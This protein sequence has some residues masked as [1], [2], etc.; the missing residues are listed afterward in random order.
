MR[1]TLPALIWIAACGGDADVPLES[2]PDE[3]PVAAADCSRSTSPLTFSGC[4]QNLLVITADTFRPD[5]LGRYGGAA[6]TPVIDALLGESL[7]LEDHRSCSNWTYVSMY[8]VQTGSYELQTG[9]IPATFE[10][11]GVHLVPDEQVL[12]S[13]VLASSGWQTGLVT[14]NTFMS[15]NVNM[16]GGFEEERLHAGAPA[17]YI[18]DSALE[19]AGA[20]DSERPWY[21]HLQYLDPHA[22]YSPPA[23]YLEGLEA[24][25][26]IDYDL[27]TDAGQTEMVEAYPSLDPETQALIRQHV[28]VRYL[29]E[30]A[31]LDD[32]VGRLLEQ[33]E[34][35]GRLADTLVVFMSDHGEQLG[36]HGTFG[37]SE[38]LYE[39][40]NR[41]I[42]AFR[43]AGLA[44]GS[45]DGP[46]THADLWPTIF[47][48]LGMEIPGHFGGV[49]LGQRGDDDP[50]YGL[51]MDD[52]GGLQM[53]ERGGVK[54]IYAWTG[55]KQLYR[56]EGDPGEQVNVYD[57]DDPEVIALWE[58]LWPAVNAASDL[59]PQFLLVNPG[60]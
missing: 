15:S 35:A 34:A 14:A 9:F 60:P 57:P 38:G 8:C 48:A 11:T 10:E 40:E 54:L 31:Y 36:E 44:P 58:L 32:Q 21:L 49:P 56:L 53:V 42:V 43:G 45:W 28:M 18:T 6:D 23:A 52:D 4:P 22:P 17:R 19:L 12:V 5:L 33:L 51:R 20:F 2:P 47:D 30:L 25:P 26:P 7:V 37:H 24:L 46:T 13:E 1:L 29:G 16:A 41:A 55:G 50:R 27:T 3:A 39:Q 59:Y